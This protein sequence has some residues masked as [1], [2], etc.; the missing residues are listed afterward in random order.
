D[1]VRQ[2]DQRSIQ[3]FANGSGFCFFWR[4]TGC[5]RNNN[6][7]RSE[8]H[9]AEK[10]YAPVNHANLLNRERTLAVGHLGAVVDATSFGIRPIG[11]L[12]Y[13][14]PHCLPASL[15]LEDG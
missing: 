11:R 5:A 7:F 15:A 3:R 6:A 12:G 13:H 8:I 2:L 14:E 1:A 4:K 9:T 10:L